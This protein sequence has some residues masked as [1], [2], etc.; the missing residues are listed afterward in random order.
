MSTPEFQA[1]LKVWSTPP[2]G[3]EAFEDRPA[4]LLAAAQAAWRAD[5]TAVEGFLVGRIGAGTPEALE[6]VGA[7]EAPVITAAL[8]ARWRRTRGWERA[9]IAELL[10]A[11][12]LRRE[13]E[14]VLVAMLGGPGTAHAALALKGWAGP[15]AL[16]PVLAALT[17]AEEENARFHLT[18]LA[19]QLAGFGTGLHRTVAWCLDFEHAGVRAWGIAALR[20]AM[21][22]RAAGRPWPV[23]VEVRSPALQALIVAVNTPGAG[24][25]VPPL[26][27]GERLVAQQVLLLAHVRRQ[28][29]RA[30]PVLRALGGELTAIFLGSS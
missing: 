13:A 9:R 27:D 23:D 12:G 29:P 26:S 14:E 17:G 5:A 4:D 18:Q 30:L 11:R 16:E 2:V 3:R 28:D 7:F 20:R 21:A 6:I 19:L 22:D 15:G 24:I 25:E 1:F 10:A 8:R